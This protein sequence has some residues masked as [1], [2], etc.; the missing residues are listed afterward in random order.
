MGSATREA[1]SAS[2]AALADLGTADVATGEQLLSAGRV[3]GDSSQ[4][5]AALADPA[6]EPANKVSIV[7]AVFASVSA[8]AR[9]LLGAVVASRWS[10][11]DD[12]L[13][14]IE[15]IGIRVLARSA[16]AGT[17]IEQEL[18]AFGAVV[19]SDAELE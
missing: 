8:G 10:S 9:S 5:L 7:N 18:F 13:A 19:S 6:A 11:S 1:L 12:L 15:E 3:I 2:R 16:K 17:A 4:L 14:A